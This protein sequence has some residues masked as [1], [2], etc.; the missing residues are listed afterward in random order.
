MDMLE[1]AALEN[2]FRIPETLFVKNIENVQGDE[3]DIIIFS[4]A[5]A[6]DK[7]G[8][9]MMQFGSLNIEKGENRLNVAITR[10]REAIYVVS[11]IYP[12]Q[13][14][15][16]E[17]K[18][19][20]PGLLKKYL[21][22]VLDVSEGNYKATLPALENVNINWFLKHKLLETDCSALGTELLQE[23]PFADLTI[24]AK[25]KYTGV[26]ITDDDLYHQSVS[27]K[28]PHVYLPFSLRNKKWKYKMVYSR[29]YWH[30]KEMVREK[31]IRFMAQSENNA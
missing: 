23:L 21:E 29:E 7:K 20:G 18:N 22:Y 2:N 19:A 27:V 12:Q 11:S 24:K 10:A 8:K 1:K 17:S 16:E 26:I 31:I 30:D 25:N 14:K 9:M 5:Y 28:E 6:P 13:L 15:V 4:I 3:K